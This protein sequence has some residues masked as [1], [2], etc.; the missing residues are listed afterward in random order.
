MTDV[1]RSAGAAFDNAA[2]HL[3]AADP[4]RTMTGTMGK[5]YRPNVAA[6]IRRADGCVL[7][8]QRSD[9]PESWQ[10]PQGGIDRGETP[11]DAI[12]R[13]VLEEVGIAAEAYELGAKRGPYRYDFPAGP[14]RRGFHGQEQWYFL[15]DLQGAQTPEPD[16]ART[17]GEFAAVRW[18]A[19]G[20]FPLERV[21]PM[22]VNVY[23]EVLRDFFGR[24][25]FSR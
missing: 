22:K 2:P 20:E 12:R 25:Q 9:F 1:E 7:L 21:P 13:E 23:R 14:D 11:E 15:C 24:I 3:P 17:C 8:G 18:V 10:F 19:I 5:R 4:R 16:L 6:I